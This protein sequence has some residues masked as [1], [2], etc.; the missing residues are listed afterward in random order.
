MPKKN[1]MLWPL[2]LLPLALLLTG[3]AHESP[4]YPVDPP[5]VPPLAKQARQPA[6]PE[7][8][9][10]TCPAGLTRLRTNLLNSLSEQL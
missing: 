4:S 8:C 5:R 6:R 2:M 7:I 3:C 9:V 1:S 10:P